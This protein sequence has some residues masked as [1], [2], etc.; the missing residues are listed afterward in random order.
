MKNISKSTIIRTVVLVVMIINQVLAVFHKS[1]LPFSDEEVENGISTVL[2]IASAVW[3]WWKNN[4][5]TKAAI[6]AD[7]YKDSIKKAS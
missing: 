1:P 6:Q 4:S 7:H 2:T 5:F 3:A